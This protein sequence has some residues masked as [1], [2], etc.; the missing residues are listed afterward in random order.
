MKFNKK[1][2]LGLIGAMFSSIVFSKEEV[3]GSQVSLSLKKKLDKSRTVLTF[4]KAIVP[5]AF[6][7][8][9]LFSNKIASCISD[10]WVSQT[11]EWITKVLASAPVEFIKNKKDFF[12]LAAG[13]CGTLIHNR[14]L[15]KSYEKKTLYYFEEEL[16]EV[17]AHNEY[18]MQ[19]TVDIE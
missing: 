10:S 19:C 11:P 15:V 5:A 2:L 6:I 1:V 17:K 8:A 9:Y 7:G 13:I 14:S 3:S 4:Q 16:A 18:L 12:Y